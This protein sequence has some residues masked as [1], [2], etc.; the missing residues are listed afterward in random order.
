MVF[1]AIDVL[2]WYEQG[3]QFVSRYCRSLKQDLY[4]WLGPPEQDF[5]LMPNGDVISTA[6]KRSFKHDASAL[7]YS[8]K[9]RVIRRLM[10]VE[11]TEK[12]KRLPWITVEHRQDATA[13]DLSEWISE[14]KST[15]PN[16]PL[17]QLVKLGGLALHYYLAEDADAEIHTVDRFGEEKTWRFVGPKQLE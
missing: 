3:Y 8:T 12:P 1:S 2:S 17:Q 16:I 14:V 11:R 6:L 5:L 10:D 15:D 4:D 9:D 13:T 7:L